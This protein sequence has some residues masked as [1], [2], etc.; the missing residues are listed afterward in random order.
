VVV[1]KV[2]RGTVTVE[3]RYVIVVTGATGAVGA[4]APELSAGSV[5]AQTPPVNVMLAGMLVMIPG[6][7]ETHFAQTPAK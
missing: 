6:F 2:T 1:T 7:L 4:L 5:G 3:V